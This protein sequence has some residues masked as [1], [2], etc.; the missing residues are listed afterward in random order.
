MEGFG[1]GGE[2]P[3][4]LVPPQ[5]HQIPDIVGLGTRVCARFRDPVSG[6]RFRDRVSGSGF[7]FWVSGFGSGFGYRSSVMDSIG[8]SNTPAKTRLSSRMLNW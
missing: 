2:D 5:R 3:L 1:V 8:A 6:S 4:A 7:G